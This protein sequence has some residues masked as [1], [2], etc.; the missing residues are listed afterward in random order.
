MKTHITLAIMAIATLLTGCCTA[1][2]KGPAYGHEQEFRQQIEA[3][4]PVQ[5]WGCKIEDIRFSDDYE[6]VLVVFDT[7]AGHRIEA[8]FAD[9]GFHRYHGHVQD[10]ARWKSG[11]QQEDFI[12]DITV[13]LPSR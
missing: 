7:T 4:V 6:K 3:S 12:Q 13:N 5:K 2:P 1:H 8:V 9:D 11:I 10:P